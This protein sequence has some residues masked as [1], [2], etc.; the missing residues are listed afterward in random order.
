MIVLFSTALRP[1][2]GQTSLLFSAK[3]G[4]FLGIK[5][6]GAYSSPFMSI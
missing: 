1:V 3:L 2:L 6:A 5:A 4:F